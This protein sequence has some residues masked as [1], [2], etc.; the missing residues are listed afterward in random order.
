MILR[1]VSV[2]D[3]IRHMSRLG[4]FVARVAVGACIAGAVALPPAPASAQT[5]AS[6]QSSKSDGPL[7]ILVSLR[8]Q[9][10]NVYDRNGLVTTSPI[11]S[12]TKSN[13][14]PTG[15]FSVLQK[16]RM[17]HSNLYYSAPMPN[18][19]R[20]TWSGVALHAGNLPGYP[21]SHGCIRLPSNFSRTLFSMTS[22]GTRVIVTD[23]PVTPA[24]FAHPGLWQALPPGVNPHTE[25]TGGEAVRS[26]ASP[27]ALPAPIKVATA[28]TAET[29]APQP[30]PQHTSTTGRTIADARAERQSGIDRTVAEIAKS[31]ATQAAAAEGVTAATEA[32]RLA[33]LAQRDAAAELAKLKNAHATA[34]SA[35]LKVEREIVG[36]VTTQTRE[37]AR[38]AKRDEKRRE[39]H[40]ADAASD[41]PIDTL[42]ARA[43]ARAVAAKRDNEAET[44][45]AEQELA[46]EAKLAGLDADE[47]AA[48]E[49]VEL[50]RQTLAARQA[51]LHDA[52]QALP[53][54]RTAYTKASKELDEA[55]QSN[56]RAVA[57]LA[58]FDKPATILISRKSNKIYIRQGFAEV[59][60]APVEFKMP[61]SPVGTHVLSALAFREGSDTELSWRLMT[62]SGIA[63]DERHDRP[64]PR[65]R[66]RAA[67]MEETAA[68]SAVEVP[69]TAANALDRVVLG[70]EA[71][72]RLREVLK[73]GSTLIVSDA[74]Q[75]R[76]TNEYT[77]II[78]EPR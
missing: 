63:A 54:A 50:Q 59:Y 26:A 32:L 42:L 76:E 47:S 38:A 35:R 23:D 31:E 18:M 78:V 36:F 27:A 45:A 14:T 1:A 29:A 25:E 66:A 28:A 22:V 10:L 6:R 53:E 52:E 51:E 61:A 57:A 48:A 16:K 41:R 24:E 64:R 37:M 67:S 69:M 71:L 2:F 39:E 12:G 55:R 72:M 43:E 20:L 70:E 68:L 5:S 21:A 77:D 13:P 60:Q 19:Q 7:T 4:Q 17:H 15:I 44:E 9:Q 8:E 33:R 11:S 74:A 62:V 3:P 58:Q 65:S 56:R 30:P 49:A 40:L 73:P 46:I 34:Q 75:S